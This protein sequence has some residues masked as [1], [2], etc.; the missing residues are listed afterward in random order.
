MKSHIY[1]PT[2]RNFVTLDVDR[3]PRSILR[4]DVVSDLFRANV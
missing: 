3:Q 4:R 1:G 2:F